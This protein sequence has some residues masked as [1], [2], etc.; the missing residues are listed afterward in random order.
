MVYTG[1]EFVP[2]QCQDRAVRA[3]RVH[4]ALAGS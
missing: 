1:V 3:E 2:A 4:Q